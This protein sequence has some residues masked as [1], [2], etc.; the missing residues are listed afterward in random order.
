MTMFRKILGPVVDEWVHLAASCDGTSTSVYFNGLFIDTVGIADNS[1]GQI[2]IGT[3]RGMNRPFI[4]TI[5]DVRVY[6]RA[7]SAA[8]IAGLAGRKGL[9]HKPL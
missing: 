8:E 1:F 3:N 4:G 7:L 9:I 5:D 2:A 6:D